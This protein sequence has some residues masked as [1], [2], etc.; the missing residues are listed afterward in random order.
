MCNMTTETQN[1]EIV[2]LSDIELDQVSGGDMTWGD[3]AEYMW[4]GAKGAARD[5]LHAVGDGINSLAD[6]IK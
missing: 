4:W 5:A 2:P 1:H 6:K 3:F